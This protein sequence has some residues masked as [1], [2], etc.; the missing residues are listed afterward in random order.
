[1]LA[2]SLQEHL[3]AIA[4]GAA[5]PATGDDDD[6][7]VASSSSNSRE[8]EKKASQPSQA[9]TAGERLLQLACEIEEGVHA[10]SGR[11]AVPKQEYRT[12]LRLLVPALRLA[13]GVAPRVLS[14]Q[15][16]PGE[17]ATLDSSALAS[18]AV[19]KQVLSLV[20]SGLCGTCVSWRLHGKGAILFVLLISCTLASG[21]LGNA[22][23]LH[24]CPS[25][26]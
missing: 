9:S 10:H 21:R 1:M 14:G 26:P 18:A 23:G 5:V 3:Q 2:K 11:S 6:T 24:S 17:L 8:E 12:R 19:R 7:R 20:W 13:D 15:L 16:T 4:A 25:L 22:L